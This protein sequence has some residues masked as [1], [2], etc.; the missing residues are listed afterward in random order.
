MSARVSGRGLGAPCS[1]DLAING[2]EFTGERL[3]I[4]ERRGAD[5]VAQGEALARGSFAF[6]GGI[7]GEFYVGVFVGG[8]PLGEVAARQQ[9]CADAGCAGAAGECENGDAHG[10]RVAGGRAAAEGIGVKGE[11]DVVVAGEM[12]VEV[13]MAG[14]PDTIEG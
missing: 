6:G 14:E 8:D 4:A 2:F 10:E 3:N 13:D 11:V 12:Q 1:P 5:L 9:A 7:D